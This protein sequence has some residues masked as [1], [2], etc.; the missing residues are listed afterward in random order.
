MNADKLE[1]YLKLVRDTYSPDGNPVVESV[2]S[3]QPKMLLKAATVMVELSKQ[4]N[5]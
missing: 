5:P 2:L 3:A 4:E 1:K